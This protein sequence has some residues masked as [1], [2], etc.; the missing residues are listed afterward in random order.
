MKY[1]LIVLSFLIILQSCNQLTKTNDETVKNTNEKSEPVNTKLFEKLQALTS[2]GI[3]IG[4]QDDIVYGHSWKTGGTSDV[5]Q[6]TGDFPAIFGWE[7][8]D[9]ELGHSHSLDSVAFSEIRDGIKWVNQQGGINTISW[10]CNNPLT[11]GN[12]WD[13]TSKEVVNSILPEG[14]KNKTYSQWLDIMADFLLSLKNEKGEL[15]LVLFRPYHEHT[16]SWF[17]WGQELCSTKE[18]IALWKFTVEYFE[19]K[20]V[21]NLLYVYSPADFSTIEEYLERYPGDDIIDIVGF[22]DYQRNI[23]EKAEFVNKIKEKAGI[24]TNYA[25]EHDK[26]AVL[27]ETGFESIP[28][29]T[30]WTETLWPAV[31]NYPL[32]YLLCWRNAHNK[33]NHYYMPFPGQKSANDFIRFKNLD[34]TLFL[35]DVQ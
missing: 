20:G 5:K 28:D 34:R 15:I 24:I 17:W 9:L 14:E 18:Y 3:M 32:S 16:G 29:S 21:K 8:G 10:H 6:T 35:S 30:W 19:K 31:K 12:A 25:K 2:K 13:V 26:I 1:I 27:S 11:N 7:L 23:N 33:P 22:D 4:H